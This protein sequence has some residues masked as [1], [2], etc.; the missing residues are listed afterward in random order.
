MRG[1]A[2]GQRHKQAFFPIECIDRSVFYIIDPR[3][4]PETSRRESCR[5]N[6]MSFQIAKLT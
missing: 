6:R 5:D 1:R 2:L 3:I 4:Q